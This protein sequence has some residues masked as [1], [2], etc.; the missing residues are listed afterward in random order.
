[1]KITGKYYR[2]EN[3]TWVFTGDTVYTIA[4]KTGEWGCRKIGKEM[5]TGG[6]LTQRLYDEWAAEAQETGTFELKEEAV[7]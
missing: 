1:M 4:R 6:V 3:F 7:A 2:D 5:F